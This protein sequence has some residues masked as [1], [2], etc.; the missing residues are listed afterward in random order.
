M[1]T[2]KDLTSGLSQPLLTPSWGSVPESLISPQLLKHPS[3]S[4]PDS[5]PFPTHALLFFKPSTPQSLSLQWAPYQLSLLIRPPASLFSAYSSNL[6]A[7]IITCF[8]NT[9]DFIAPLIFCTSWANVNLGWTPL[10]TF[11]LSCPNDHFRIITTPASSK[12]II[13]VTFSQ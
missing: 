10:S 13:P 12:S 2:W 11:S 5:V 8:T 6:M 3:L 9:R 4:S 1:H 7:E